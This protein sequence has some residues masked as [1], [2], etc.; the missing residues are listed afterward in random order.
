[1]H[2]TETPRSRLT[3]LDKSIL[4]LQVGVATTFGIVGFVQTNDPDWGS[5][6]RLVILFMLGL[7]FGGIA[8]SA[9][10]AL[11]FASPVVRAV[12]LIVGP[13]LGL[14]ILVGWSYLGA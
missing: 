11:R 12:I 9:A 7:W 14:L 13:F 6:Q 4:V 3:K 8:G 2:D 1:M 10:I 5:L